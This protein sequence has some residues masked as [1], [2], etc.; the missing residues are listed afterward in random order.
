M[1]AIELFNWI[2]NA[3]DREGDMT[4]RRLQTLLLI[5]DAGKGGISMSE[6]VRRTKSTSAGTTK[7]VQ[8]WSNR[9]A[10]KTRGPAY[11][12]ARADQDNLSTK[13]VYITQRG[14][15]AVGEL[16]SDA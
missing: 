12:V 9:T 16:L 8:S 5:Y 2:G 4:L 3:R 11:V 7:L 14:Q 1:D 13:T 15:R 6:I 10:A